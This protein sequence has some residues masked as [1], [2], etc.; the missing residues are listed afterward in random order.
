MTVD[1][2]R[3]KQCLREFNFGA[4]LIEELGWDRHHAH[5]LPVLVDGA[6][7]ALNALAEKRGMV[8]YSCDPESDGQI[9]VYAIRRK[10]EK[11]AAK[12]AHEHIIIYADSSNTYQ[13]WQWV[14]REPGKPAAC[15]EHTF[16]KKQPGDALIQKL[17]AIAFSLDE[18]E[19]LTIAHVAGRAR[20]AFD[21]DRITK[22]FYDRFKKEHGVFLKFIKGIQDKA[23]R[24][25]YASLMLNRLMFIYFIQKKGF[26]DGDIN[27]LRN[28]MRL[29]QQHKGKDRF[30][31]FYRYFLLRLFHDGLGQQE[32]TAELDNLLGKVPFLNGGLFDVHDLER[33]N[34]NIEMPDK[35]FEKLFDFFDAYQWHLDERPLRAD[36]EINPDVLGYI[37]EKYINQ[38]QMGA[39]YT[40]E[41]ITEYITKNTVIP[42]L[43]NAA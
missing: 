34:P 18:E 41:D 6:T 20:Q 7:Y 21:V 26:L 8:V 23:S 36:N 13:I 25:W 2:P 12:S 38:K 39:Y 31:S 28:R 40:K 35:A 29:M 27:Y 10:I 42:Y 14:K 32:R 16:H 17:Q 37:F 30:L 1:I 3:I 5:P 11:Q 24:E 33:D 15:R 9:P 43:F 19:G 22:R 4:L